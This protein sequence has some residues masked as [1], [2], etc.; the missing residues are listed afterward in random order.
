MKQ[1][2]KII[3]PIIALCLLG[4]LVYS[5]ITKLENKSDVAKTLQTIPKFH[6]KT[7]DNN[8]FENKDLSSNNPIIFIYFNT[9]CD[10]CHHEAQS[11][12]ENIILFKEIELLFVSTQ[13][14]EIIKQFAIKHNLLNQPNITFLN[15]KTHLFADR[16]DANS[17]PFLL[18]YDRDQNLIKKHKGQLKPEAILKLLNPSQTGN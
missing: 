16:F 9:E 14:P 11:I 12:S 2:L 17:I 18:I 4:Y 13:E 6:F 8:D 1:K 7:L 15:D 3:I 10:F 5:I